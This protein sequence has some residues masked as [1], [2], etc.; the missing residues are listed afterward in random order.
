MQVDLMDRVEVRI[1][2]EFSDR[3]AEG[4]QGAGPPRVEQLCVGT[5]MRARLE[6]GA[7]DIVRIRSEDLRLPIRDSGSGGAAGQRDAG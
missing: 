4:L 5:I 2:C 3:L 7:F 6:G 1:T